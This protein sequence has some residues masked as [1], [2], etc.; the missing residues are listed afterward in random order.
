MMDQYAKESD[1]L[2]NSNTRVD[3]YIQFGRN[4][5]NELYEQRSIMKVTIYVYLNNFVANTKENAGYC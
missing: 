4:A 2:D 1:V 5:L 3:E